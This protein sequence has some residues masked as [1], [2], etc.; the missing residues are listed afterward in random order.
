MGEVAFIDHFGNL[1][2]NIPADLLPAARSHCVVRIGRR[3]IR[4]IDS[5]YGDRRSGELL[6]LIES[7]GH[8]E[9]AVRDGNASLRTRAK[10]GTLV[11][12]EVEVEK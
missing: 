8:L 7:T 5:T 9:V 10:I 12:V 6:S 11:K 3:T 1:V 4:G 2:T